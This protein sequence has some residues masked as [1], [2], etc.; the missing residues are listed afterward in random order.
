[1][2]IGPSSSIGIFLR[3]Q[4]AAT[5]G[6]ETNMAYT[7]EE[8]KREVM[9]DLMDEALRDPKHLKT[10]LDRLVEEGRLRG[11]APEIRT[12]IQTP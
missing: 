4:R 2:V 3:A 12:R 5:G 1:M 10:A 7:V 6:L 11:L 9:R 8:F